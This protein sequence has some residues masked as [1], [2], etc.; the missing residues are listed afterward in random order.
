MK[1]RKKKLKD[2]KK[3]TQD[4]TSLLFSW[5]CVKEMGEK[6]GD[7]FTCGIVSYWNGLKEKKGKK[8]KRGNKKKTKIMET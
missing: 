6:S 1:K 8:K 2:I 7:K 3:K 5:E 4:W